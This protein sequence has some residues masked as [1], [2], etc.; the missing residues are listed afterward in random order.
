M[1]N[2]NFNKEDY[3]A[4]KQTAKELNVYTAQSSDATL[5]IGG[6]TVAFMRTTENL[7]N[8]MIAVAVS[9]C[10][11]EDEFKKKTGKYQALLKLLD[12]SQYVQL[13]LGQYLR[14]AGSKATGELLLE[15]FGD[16]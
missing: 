12:Y 9:Y 10:A 16:V 4:L 14:R 6:V 13:P 2:P 8:R 5:S 1:N 7:E 11:P 15:M 3:K